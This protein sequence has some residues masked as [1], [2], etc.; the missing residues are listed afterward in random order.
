MAGRAENPARHPRNVEGR[1]GRIVG[2]WLVESLDDGIEDLRQLG[3][4]DL[5]LMTGLEAMS[6]QPRTGN[7]IVGLLPEADGRRQHVGT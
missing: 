3:L 4:D 5:R 7:F 1:D 6:D 2:E